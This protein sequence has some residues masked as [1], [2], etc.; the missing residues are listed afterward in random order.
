MRFRA[1]D[2]SVLKAFK[3]PL[4]AVLAAVFLSGGLFVGEGVA[5]KTLSYAQA[6]AGGVCLLE[7]PLRWQQGTGVPQVLLPADVSLAAVP[8]IPLFSQGLPSIALPS[9]RRAIPHLRGP[10]VFQI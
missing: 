3:R 8:A 10:P 9:V 5:A 4:A 1:L 7:S 2:M 6:H